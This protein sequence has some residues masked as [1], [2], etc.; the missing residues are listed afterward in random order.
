MGTAIR[1]GRSLVDEAGRCLAIH[2]QTFD[3]ARLQECLGKLRDIPLARP[4]SAGS[5]AA[6]LGIPL[7]SM[8]GRLDTAAAS[9]P[10]ADLPTETHA[11]VLAPYLRD[12]LDACPGQVVFARLMR[13]DPGGY[14]SNHRDPWHS[15]ATGL[16]RLQVPIDHDDR[17][18]L[19]L[20]GCEL[21]LGA[22]ELWY[23][24]VSAVHGVKNCGAMPRHNI[25]IDVEFTSALADAVEDY[26]PRSDCLITR[27][28]WPGSLEL[29]QYQCRVEV[30]LGV[31]AFVGGSG[32]ADI[33]VKE[34][35]LFIRFHD[36][37]M[38]RLRPRA[39]GSLTINGGPPGVRLIYRRVKGTLRG[40]YLQFRGSSYGR[41]IKSGALVELP[42]L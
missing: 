42:L 16:V 37:H 27:D 1:R 3:A 5:A 18:H 32:P 4:A 21:Q 28:V 31:A 15:P 22:G 34:G 36:G 29:S 40:L 19:V 26:I 25:L 24:D 10:S 11:L 23:T 14:I 20:G 17:S 8:G 39:S 33:V 2:L 12:V 35:A 38:V 7:V 30:P 9:A 6:W 41:P 13:M